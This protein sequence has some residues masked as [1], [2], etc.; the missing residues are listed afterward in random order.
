MTKHSIAYLISGTVL[1]L[2]DIAYLAG[3]PYLYA[4]IKLSTKNYPST[5][6]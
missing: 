4:R 6:E 2:H 5:N 1:V 3:T